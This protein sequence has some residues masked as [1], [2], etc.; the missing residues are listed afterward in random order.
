MKKNFLF[1][2]VLLFFSATAYCTTLSDGQTI[3]EQDSTITKGVLENGLTYYVQKN[4]SYPKHMT[5]CMVV[6]VGSSDETISEKGYAHFV[7]HMAFQGTTNFPGTMALDYLGSKGAMLGSEINAFT[8]VSYTQYD[9]TALPSEKNVLDSV[10][11]I[12]R[13]FA[14]EITFDPKDVSNE[15]KVIVEELHMSDNVDR[16]LCD[17]YFSSLYDDDGFHMVNIIG[18]ED[19]LKYITSV[20]LKKFY[21]KWYVPENIA[22]V[23]VGD[24]DTEYACNKIE[25]LFSSMPHRTSPQKSAEYKIPEHDN[26]DIYIDKNLATPTGIITLSHE[27]INA[28]DPVR[29]NEYCYNDSLFTHLLE[30]RFIDIASRP[31]SPFL[32]IAVISNYGKSDRHVSLLFNTKQGEFAKG[33]ETCIR[34]LS[35]IYTLGFTDDE[36]N[37]AALYIETKA[38][39]NM[40]LC[41]L[42]PFLVNYLY[43][44]PLVSPQQQWLNTLSYNSELLRLTCKSW[45]DDIKIL[46]SFVSPDISFYNTPHMHLFYAAPGEETLE[47]GGAEEIVQFM[48]ESSVPDEVSFYENYL[49]PSFAYSRSDY[50]VFEKYFKLPTD[51]TAAP[52]FK[53][54]L[55]NGITVVHTNNGGSQAH[56]SLFV[57]GGLA[58]L[59]PGDYHLTDINSINCLEKARSIDGYSIDQISNY[60]YKEIDYSK[61]VYENAAVMEINFPT[62]NLEMAF[63]FL[64]SYFSHYAYNTDGL[65]NVKECMSYLAALS[66]NKIEN[67]VARHYNRA[68]CH[69][70]IQPSPSLVANIT[71]NDIER[72]DKALFGNLD[73]ATLYL[74]GYFDKDTLDKFM[75]TLLSKLPTGDK[76]TPLEPY[77]HEYTESGKY[78]YSIPFAKKRNTAVS[79]NY[80]FSI[81]PELKERVML[82]LVET[83]MYHLLLRE[84]REKNGYIYSPYCIKH[85]DP[86]N[87]TAAGLTIN[88]NCHTDN[89]ADATKRSHKCLQMIAKGKI[90]D[91]FFNNCKA[92]TNAKW[93]LAPSFEQTWLCEQYQPLLESI[94][95]KDV[96]RFCKKILKDGTLIQNIFTGEK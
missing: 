33:L 3:N 67:H 47:F 78:E 41:T 2:F 28:D 49:D 72:I 11:M 12:M 60:F 58:A 87:K 82:D 46:S 27:R 84:L 1:I 77:R 53:K 26:V 8:Q 38:F 69:R 65:N 43:G 7:E 89:A 85:F 86:T 57:P 66:E 50:R 31:G 91:E 95:L 19:W 22:V 5:L 37:K 16:R 36:F 62:Y 79:L 54:V 23:L 24:I 61:Q 71:L 18:S 13:D 32:D 73:G 56:M 9:F 10:I 74:S 21:D 45:G 68:H 52:S 34:T 81:A 35:Q 20:E 29:F 63:D 83:M 6:N 70:T 4:D 48:K 17:N 51:T 30:Q 40:M 42:Q 75:D 15:K 92:M 39:N 96:S 94:T 14:S 93:V 88:F 44:W 55:D 59:S 90:S 64:Y 25:E 76:I 80:D